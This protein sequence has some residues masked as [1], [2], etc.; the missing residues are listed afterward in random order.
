MHL[1]RL[2]PP[3]GLES[4]L[5]R[6]SLESL[7]EDPAYGEKRYE[8]LQRNLGEEKRVVTCVPTRLNGENF[9]SRQII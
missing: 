1:C 6:T 2:G 3:A 7:Y 8:G 5:A 9:A 4:A